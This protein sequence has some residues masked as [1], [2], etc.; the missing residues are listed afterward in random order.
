LK[1][2]QLFKAPFVRG[3]RNIETGLDCQGLFI[4]LMRYYGHEVK[5]S[6]VAEYAT[7]EVA[8]VVEKEI[9]SGKW[10]KLNEP[11]IGCAVGMALDSMF[12]FLVQHLGI[13]IGEGKF[14][15]ILEKRGVVTN[16]I[17]DRF[18]SGKIRGYYRW[19]G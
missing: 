12:P 15:H 6:F 13:Y 7:Q 2:I 1:L 9:G 4:E 16:K 8:Q 18:F 5:E 10:L 17:T 14:I 11:E 19:I 3:G